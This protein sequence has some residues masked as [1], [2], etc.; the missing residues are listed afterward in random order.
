M[1]VVINTLKREIEWAKDWMQKNKDNKKAIKIKDEQIKKFERA[2]EILTNYDTVKN[3]ANELFNMV[4]QT[5]R[6]DLKVEANN[7][8]ESIK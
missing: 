3:T 4:H 6:V 1:E 2:I 7:L 8:F 5:D